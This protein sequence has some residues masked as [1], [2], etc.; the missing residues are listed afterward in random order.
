MDLATRDAELAFADL[1]CADVQ[2]LREEFDA[3]IAASFDQPPAAPPPA[4]PRVPPHRHHP[5]TPARRYPRPCCRAM[6]PPVT[7]PGHCRQR[8]PPPQPSRA[9]LRPPQVQP[10]QPRQR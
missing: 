8:S 4:P 3:L 7:A 6:T 10:R 5:A 9:R 1:I 2:W